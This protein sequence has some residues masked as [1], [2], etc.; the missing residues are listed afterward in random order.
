MILKMYAIKDRLNDFMPMQP[1]PNNE[2]A[3]RWFKE[4]VATNTIMKMNPNDFSIWHIGEWDTTEGT[5]ENDVTELVINEK[6]E[7]DNG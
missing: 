3:I 5:F 2:S 4:M 7:K 6:G 1:L